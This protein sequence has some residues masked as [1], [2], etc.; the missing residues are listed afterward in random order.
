MDSRPPATAMDTSPVRIWSAAIMRAFMPDP[1]ILLMVVV[2]T[3]WGILAPIAAWRAGAWPRPAGNTQPMM[4]SCTSAG[5]MPPRA[6]A[7]AIA[8]A[9]SCGAV[10]GESTP[11]NAP[12]GVRTAE[13][14][15]TSGLSMKIS[16]NSVAAAQASVENINESVR[17]LGGLEAGILAIPVAHPVERAGEREGCHFRVAVADGAVGDTGLDE[18]AHAAI[19]AGLE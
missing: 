19:D 18:R 7:P 15:T 10:A 9:P 16:C 5:P 11:W 1:H 12:M 4:T 6:I 3:P 8:A 14:M 17:D 13:V 2:G